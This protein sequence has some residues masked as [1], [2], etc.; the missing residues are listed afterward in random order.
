MLRQDNITGLSDAPDFDAFFSCATW[1]RK[2]FH[3]SELGVHGTAAFTRRSVVV[4]V[5][6]EADLTFASALKSA[7]LSGLAGAY[8]PVS[9]CATQR[10]RSSQRGASLCSTSNSSS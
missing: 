8:P 9:H 3:G 2:G 6:A 1:A 4:R 7:G 5:K 10:S